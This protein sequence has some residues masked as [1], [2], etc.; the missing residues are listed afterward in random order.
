MA[1][2]IDGV[3]DQLGNIVDRSRRE[4]SRLGLA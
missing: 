2:T 4:R 1:T 3:I